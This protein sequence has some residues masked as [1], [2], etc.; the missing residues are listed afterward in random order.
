MPQSLAKVLVHIV[1]STKNRYPFLADKKIRDEL[2]AYLGGTC[3]ELECPVLTVGGAVDHVHI[4]CSLSRNHSIASFVGDIKRGSSKWI[5][6]KGRMLAKFAWQNG[7]GMFSV[8]ESE[9]ERVKQYIVG[10][11]GHHRKKTFQDE[12]RSFLKE[13]GVN[14][15]ERY[16]WD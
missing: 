12:Y 5:K 10:Q 13:Y 11:E 1:F 14:F 9:M 6:T 7:Y 4:L 15:D 8:G 2:H 3:N 16:V